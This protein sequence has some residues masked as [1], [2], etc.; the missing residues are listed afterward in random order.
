MPKHAHVLTEG[1]KAVLKLDDPLPGRTC[2]WG[3]EPMPS[4]L[5]WWQSAPLK[6]QGHF[7]S[8]L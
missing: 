3:A 2:Q 5:L 4:F 8:A 7:Q 1:Y 6:P